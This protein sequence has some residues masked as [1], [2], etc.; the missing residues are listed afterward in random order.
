[1]TSPRALVRVRESH[2][3]P[4]A[5][6]ATVL[7]TACA[8]SQASSEDGAPSGSAQTAATATLSLEPSATLTPSPSPSA[9]QTP[10]AADAVLTNSW[11]GNAWL[12][13][14]LVADGRLTRPSDQGWQVR[15]LS[16]SGIDEMVAAVVSTGLFD[17][18]HHIPLELQPGRE[19][20]GCVPE[21]GGFTTRTIEL[22]P[23]DEPIRVS[24]IQAIGPADCYVPSPERDTLEALSAR[25]VAP[26]DWLPGSAWTD[27]ISRPLESSSFR[28]VVVFQREV[29]ELQSLPD[30][31]AVDWPFTATPR[32]FGDPLAEPSV[33]PNRTER[34][35]V[36]D[37]DE[38]A[39]V[40][41]AFADVGAVTTESYPEGYASAFLVAD[42]ARDGVAAVVLEALRPEERGCQDNRN[43]LQMLNCWQVDAVSP[44]DCAVS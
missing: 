40:R 44:F 19:P 8:P 26:E 39:R 37:R 43:A 15:V 34:C 35:G 41:E 20:A 42:R 4:V 30:L 21:L 18:N 22:T 16:P 13:T 7:L 31:R 14:S 1:M 38:A 33:W 23:A 5:V 10:A 24:W 11:S 29:D 17:R 6:I 25:L 2:R 3:L 9:G 12:T 36:I 27:P 28:L 32:E